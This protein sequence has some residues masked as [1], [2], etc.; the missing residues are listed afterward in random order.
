VRS[1]L[2][3]KIEA[4]HTMKFPPSGKE[5]NMTDRFRIDGNIFINGSRRLRQTVSRYYVD[6][7]DRSDPNRDCKPCTYESIQR[8]VAYSFG[9]IQRMMQEFEPCIVPAVIRGFASDLIFQ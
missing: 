4:S 9:Q 8:V 3:A 2:V 1:A 7:M 5:C 6:V